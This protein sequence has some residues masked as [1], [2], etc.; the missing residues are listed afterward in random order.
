MRERVLNVKVLEKYMDKN[1]QC[2]S[3]V[4][5]WLAEVRSANWERPNDVKDRYP[6]A[7]ILSENRIVFNIK[8]NAYRLLC[9]VAYQSGTVVVKQIGTHAEYNNWKL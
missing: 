4:K 7:S 8:G 3:S 6:S 1:A 2:Q 5:A 9:R